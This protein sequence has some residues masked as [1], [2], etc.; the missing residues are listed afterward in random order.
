MTSQRKVTESYHPNGKLSERCYWK[1]D[2]AEH[3]DVLDG[4]Q[5]F[6]D[7]NGQLIRRQFWLAGLPHGI[8]ECYLNGQLIF[9]CYRQDGFKD[10]LEEHYY[11]NGQRKYR[12]EW[13]RGHKHGLEEIWDSKGNLTK[14]E[15]YLMG[16]RCREVTA[17][18]MV[19]TSDRGVTLRRFSITI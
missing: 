19:R 17:G 9:R 1:Q 2:P 18:S 15:N 16:N 3:H 6:W 14:R 5:E 8:E 10:S 4:P 11:P 12:C 13:I 7:S